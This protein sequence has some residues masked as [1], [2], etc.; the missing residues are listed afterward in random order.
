VSGADSGA[1]RSSLDLGKNNSTA[2]DSDDPGRYDC[3]DAFDDMFFAGPDEERAPYRCGSWDCYCCGYKMR[4]NLI[5]E[6]Q[7]ITSERPEMCRMLT[8]TL[9]PANAPPDPDE[10][11][12]YITERWNALRT[13]LKREIGDFSY[14]WVREEQE[15]G[16]PHLHALV[17]RFLPQGTVA[18]AWS[19]LG[20]GEI[21]DIRKIEHLDKAAHYVGKYLTKEA[22]TGL[23]DGIRR[24]GS[25]ADLDLDVRGSGDSEGD[26]RL[27]KEDPVTNVPRPVVK[28]DFIRDPDSRDNPPPD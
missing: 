18:T 13:R 1:G 6:I 11:H 16:L 12:Q 23:P 25:S 22:L 24:Y 19:D 15:N 4:Q 17:S 20:G 5:E 9:D 3:R 14:I 26:W 2:A 28:A 27:L 7:R 8:L 21:V 10:Q